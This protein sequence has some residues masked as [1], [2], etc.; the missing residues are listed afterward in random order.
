MILFKW[1]RI[2]DVMVVRTFLAQALKIDYYKWS[3]FGPGHAKLYS[4]VL[5]SY[6]IH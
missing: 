3:T 5:F 2:K 4:T 6:L 1:L